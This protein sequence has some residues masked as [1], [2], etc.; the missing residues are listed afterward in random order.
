MVNQLIEKMKFDEKRHFEV[1]R[2]EG[3]W[4]KK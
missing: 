4:G 3:K 1:E 2:I